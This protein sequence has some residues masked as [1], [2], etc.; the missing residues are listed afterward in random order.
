MQQI[1]QTKR[2]TFAN[3]V[4]ASERLWRKSLALH[5]VAAAH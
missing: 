3:R 4:A 5:P 2:N 1:R